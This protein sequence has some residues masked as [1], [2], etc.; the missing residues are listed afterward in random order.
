M[1]DHDGIPLKILQENKSVMVCR[2]EATSTLGKENGSLS[3]YI[4]FWFGVYDLCVVGT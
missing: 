2:F 3:V 1:I 4:A